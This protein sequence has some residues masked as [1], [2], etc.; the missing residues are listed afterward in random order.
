[1]EKVIAFYKFVALPD[2]ENLRAPWKAK[3]LS[4]GIKGTILLAREGINGSL[5]GS[6]DGID[7]MV[8]FLREDPRFSDLE[9]KESFADLTSFRRMLVKLKKEIV[10]LR[11]P[12]V[13]PLKETGHYLPPALFKKWRDEKKDMVIVDTRNDYE[14]ALGTFDEALDPKIKVFSQFPAWVKDNLSQ[15]KDRVIVTF[16]TGG[17]RCEKATAYMVQEGFKNVYQLQGG[18]LKYFEEEKGAP[19]WQGDCVVFDKRKALKPDLSVSEKSICYVCLEAVQSPEEDRCP[20]CK[21][22]MEVAHQKRQA[23]GLERHK[24]NRMKRDLF[25]KERKNHVASE[26]RA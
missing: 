23:R 24:E 19:H 2:Y 14:V 21:T 16:C 5:A 12:Q 22:A 9:A 11:V 4:L 17:I 1:M 13:D 26:I 20:A 25:L 8:S 15:D 6:K 3:A 18:I 7:A 10:T